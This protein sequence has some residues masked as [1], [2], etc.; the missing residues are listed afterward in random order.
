MHDGASAIVHGK[1][2]TQVTSN[3]PAELGEILSLV[4]TDLI[5]E[6]A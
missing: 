4:A 6:L 3:T 1:E 2:F 5:P